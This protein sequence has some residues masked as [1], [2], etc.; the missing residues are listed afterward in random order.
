[1]EDPNE[2]QVGGEHYR[3]PFQHWDLIFDL[4]QNLIYFQ[5]CA[6]KYAARWRKKHVGDQIKQIEDLEKVEHY[7]DKMIWLI[8]NVP[9]LSEESPFQDSVVDGYNLFVRENDLCAEDTVML[10][11]ILFFRNTADLKLAKAMAAA[12]A[13]GCRRSTAPAPA[14]A[15]TVP[16]APAPAP[17][18][19]FTPQGGR[20]GCSVAGCL[21]RHSAPTC[22][23]RGDI[24]TVIREIGNGVEI[25]YTAENGTPFFLTVDKHYVEILEQSQ[26]T[27]GMEHPFGYDAQ[28]EG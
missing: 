12:L 14:P 13:E 26:K 11:R 20:V 15:A 21:A 2:R 28:Q 25:R 18:P 27:D 4:S 5:G 24:G 9:T 7:V 8:E 17:A 19:R 16:A 10:S 1:M 3:A 23:Y 6:T 22:V